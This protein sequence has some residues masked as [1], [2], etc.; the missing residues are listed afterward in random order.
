MLHEVRIFNSKGKQTATISQ[1]KVIEDFQKKYFDDL[2]RDIKPNPKIKIKIFNKQ[3]F[4]C[5]KNY[6]SAIPNQKFC[7]KK[8]LNDSI[9][10]RYAEKMRRKHEHTDKFK[11]D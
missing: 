11:K 8:C 3:C 6:K 1:K 7:N 2:P 4:N 9:K 10:K 5:K